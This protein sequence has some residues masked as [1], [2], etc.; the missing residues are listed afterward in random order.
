[1]PFFQPGYNPDHMQT[2]LTTLESGA[3]LLRLPMPAVKS[4]TVL[5]L[6]NTG[7]RYE[8]PEWA[9]I[10]HF[11]EH[12][13]FKGT[14]N[15]ANSQELSSAIDTVGGEFNA[16][17]SKEYTGYYVK[18]ASRFA[19]TALHVV[20][21]MLCT[22]LL[23]PEDISREVQVIK[24]EIN[25]YEDMPMRRIGDVYDELLYQGSSLAGEV[26]GEKDTISRLTRDNFVE[27]IN[28]WY[29][30]KN[31]VL[32]VAG[33]ESVVGDDQLVEKVETAFSKGGAER[34][35]RD[36]SEFFHQ[37]P[38]GNMQEKIVFKETEQ[39]HFVLGIP[40]FSRNDNRKYT[41]SVLSNLLGR[42]MSSRLFTEIRDK[43]G[44]CY[45]IRSGT[46]FYHDAGSF[47]VSAGVDPNRI[48]EAIVAAKQEVLN[49]I[50][51]RPVKEKELQGAK[52]NMIGSLLLELED[53]QSVAYWYGLR[54]LLENVVESEQEV[55]KRLE[56]I[57]LEQLNQVANDLFKAEEL[58]LALIGP[59]QPD[60]I[61]WK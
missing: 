41:L 11:L 16:F 52:Q 47:F 33:D 51:N 31:V 1:V 38:Y 44:L 59:Y 61:K 28:N 30:F 48:E 55:I 6:V 20:S 23:R 24:E 46:D 35:A 14:Q 22:P 27:Y 39:A 17:T 2:I 25:M 32:V 60:E 10:S 13:V 29:G 34:Q 15:F 37:Q 7:R 5:A 4:L 3:K 54:L 53:T 50:G 49:V 21:D 8:P 9:G 26:L 36:Q 43:R 45:Y 56:A 40:S 12:L 19:D 42:T 18:L 57:N 58:R